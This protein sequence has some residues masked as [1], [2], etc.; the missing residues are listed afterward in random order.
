MLSSSLCQA[1]INQ[2]GELEF[3]GK[4]LNVELP[5]HAQRKIWIGQSS[6]QQLAVVALLVDLHQ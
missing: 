1:L 5:Q 3:C 4:L 2:V 6:S